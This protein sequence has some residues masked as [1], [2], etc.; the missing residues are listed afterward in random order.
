VSGGYIL[1]GLEIPTIGFLG[2]IIV[3][4]FPKQAKSPTGVEN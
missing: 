4:I 1:H 2:G 3:N